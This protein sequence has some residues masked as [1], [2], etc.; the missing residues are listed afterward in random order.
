MCTRDPLSWERGRYCL[1]EDAGVS[2]EQTRLLVTEMFERWE[3]HG[4]TGPFLSALADDL[5]WTVTGSSPIAGT[6]DSK[7]AYIEGV[8]QRLDSRLEHWPIPRVRRIVADGDWA[9]V[10]WRGVDGR[11]RRGEDYTMD[12]TWWLRIADGQIREV[13]GFYDGEKVAVLF[14]A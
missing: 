4:D 1:C 13:I 2:T 8:Y 3:H 14:A 5:S 9:V 6:Y 12:Y 10:F 7:A 11:G